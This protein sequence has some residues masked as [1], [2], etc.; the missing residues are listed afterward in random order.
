[1]A[2]LFYTGSGTSSLNLD[3]G[4]TYGTIDTG[5]LRRK[6]NFGDRVSELAIAQ[7]PFFRFVSKL[8][9]KPTDDPHFQFTEK[10]GS[11]HKRYAYVTD[12]GATSA[13]GNSGDSTWD[14]G[15]GAQ[16][17]T[18]YFKMGTDYLSAGNR[19]NVYGQSNNDISVGDSGTAPEFFLE[20]QLVKS[21]HIQQANRL[22]LVVARL[23]TMQ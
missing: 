9:K 5:D 8:N 12:H 3:T 1:M 7:D 20:G 16:G 22:V 18:Y 4:A 13:L 10:R 19:Q 23:I 11:Y 6:Y 14:S 21:T 15:E 2:D 17:D